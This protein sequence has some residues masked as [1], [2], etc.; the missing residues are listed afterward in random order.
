MSLSSH[1]DSALLSFFRESAPESTILVGVASGG[2]GPFLPAHNQRDRRL[3]VP[4][5]AHR[6]FKSRAEPGS[7]THL[8][9]SRMNTNGNNSNSSPPL[10]SRILLS[11]MVDSSANLRKEL[12]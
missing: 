5:G 7:M 6:E 1:G 9:D 12:K 4:S 10:A 8:L 3:Q 11:N 2:R